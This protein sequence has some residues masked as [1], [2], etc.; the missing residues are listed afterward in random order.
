MKRLLSPINQAR[1]FFTKLITNVLIGKSSNSEFDCIDASKVKRVLIS[2]PNHR[3]GNQLLITPLVQEVSLH[4]PNAK[5]DLFV[6]GGVAYAIFENFESV[7]EI[8]SLPKNHFSEIISYFKKWFQLRNRNYDLAINSAFGSSSGKFSVKLSKA[9]FKFYGDFL[10]DKS[11]LFP[12]AEIQHHAK[13]P[14]ISFRNFIKKSNSNSAQEQFLTLNLKLS[15]HE[16]LKGKQELEKLNP[17]SQKPTI[18][19]FTFATGSKCYQESWWL[20]FLEVLKINFQHN[21]NLIEIL[22]IENVSKIKFALPSFYSTN[23][24]EIG[25]LIANTKLFIGADSGM[26]HLACATQTTTIGLFSVTDL[27]K[28]GTFGNNS[29]SINTNGLSFEEMALKISKV[30]K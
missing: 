12:A 5:I 2:R 6:K 11:E 9:R 8:I 27:K 15:N 23:I 28:Y 13:R 22:P 19:L 25:G 3:L 24:R 20:E 1:R 17:N 4:F 14:V 21:Y 16:I 7:N 18:A 30:L 29:F 26:M 10:N